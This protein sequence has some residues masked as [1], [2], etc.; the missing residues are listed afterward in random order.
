[1]TNAKRSGRAAAATAGGG[2]RFAHEACLDKWRKTNDVIAQIAVNA[3]D[4]IKCLKDENSVIVTGPPYP[5]TTE[6]K[7]KVAV[8]RALNRLGRVVNDLSTIEF[9]RELEETASN[10]REE[11]ETCRAKIKES[12]T[13]LVQEEER[14]KTLSRELETARLSA[15][16]AT[17]DRMLLQERMRSRDGD[18][19]TKALSEEMLQL[20]AKEES[21]RAENERLKKENMTAIKEKETRTNSLKIATI[22]VANVERYKESNSWTKIALTALAIN[23]SFLAGYSES[24][25]GQHGI[26]DEGVYLEIIPPVQFG[27]FER[28]KQSE[29]ALNAAQSRLQELQ[30][31]VDMSRGQ[32]LEE[33][34]AEV[35]EIIL[36]SLMK[37]GN[38]VQEWEEK[39]I[40]AHEKLSQVITSRDWHERSFVEV[41][42]K[43]D[44]RRLEV[45]GIKE[46][47]STGY[48][49]G[50][51][52]LMF[53]LAMSPT[54]PAQLASVG[55]E[56]AAALKDIEIQKQH[57][58]DKDQEIIK[59]LTQLEKANTQLET[60][61]KV[62]GALMKKKEAVEWELMEAQAQRVKW[63]EGFQ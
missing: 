31:E 44:P 50:S 52:S 46:V 49:D 33:A 24:D 61:L 21:L 27:P 19:G 60:Q 1:M 40:T 38:N 5:Q 53:S 55:S 58:F 41:S 29:A 34:S 43:A 16:L 7:K 12:I 59:L 36:D 62:N 28:L 39:L 42:E 23:L 54:I 56:L 13:R 51:L 63:Q 18:R 30:K 4:A 3:N 57:V 9:Y 48:Y 6:S 25:G 35:Q 15:E 22:A 2:V 11:L 37:R 32:W 47:Q 14:V 26:F 45:E 8:K 17:K 20:A 10:M